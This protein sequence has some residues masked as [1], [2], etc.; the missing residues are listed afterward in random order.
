[1]KNYLFNKYCMSFYGAQLLPF[2]DKS[3]EAIFRSWRVAVR[4]VWQIPW[5]THCNFLPHITGTMRPHLWMAKRII[6]F[7]ISGLNSKNKYVKYILE[8][9]TLSAYSVFGANFRSLKYMYN[10]EIS[11]INSSWQQICQDDDD[12]IRKAMQII[13]LCKMRE[14]FTN[15]IFTRQE[16]NMIINYLCTE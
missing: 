16:C 5:K 4:R 7:I 6:N 12:I 2:H 9:G 10:L 13:E 14:D 11:K 3:M 8:M 1:M 15:D